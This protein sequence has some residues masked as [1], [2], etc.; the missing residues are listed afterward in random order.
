VI[1]TG[2]LLRRLGLPLALV[3]LATMWWVDQRPVRPP[4]DPVDARLEQTRSSDKAFAFEDHEIEPLADFAITARVLSRENYR[5][6]RAAV[7]SPV[8][9]ALGWGPMS[10][11]EVLRRLTISQGGRWYYYRWSGE[12]PLPVNEIVRHSANM[13]LIP[14]DADV[15]TALSRVRPGHVVELRG[16]LVEARGSD[17]FRWRSSLTR[18]DSGNGACEI[19]F[20]ERI[21]LR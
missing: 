13:H 19:V 15:E 21:A 6:D 8:D 3:L 5:F 17:G 11:D 20:V 1:A 14:A 16:K 9:L 2:D 12:P 7:L 4:A 10:N 18:E